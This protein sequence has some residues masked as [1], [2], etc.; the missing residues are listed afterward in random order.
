MGRPLLRPMS[1]QIASRHRAH[2]FLSPVIRRLLPNAGD[3][4]SFRLYEGEGITRTGEG[5]MFMTAAEGKVVGLSPEFIAVRTGSTRFDV[6]AA[7]CMDTPVAVGNTVKLRYYTMR[8]FDGLRADGLRDGSAATRNTTG[9]LADDIRVQLPLRWEGKPI[10]H[11]P[12]HVVS[13]YPLAR[14]PA[15]VTLAQALE[16]QMVGALRNIPA[17]LVDAGAS[18]IG[19]SEI[20]IQ[21]AF[22]KPMA[23]TGIAR[24][25]MSVR[26]R[27]FRGNVIFAYDEVNK[28]YGL[29][30]ESEH[31][32]Q[33]SACWEDLRP[34][35]LARKLMDHVDDGRWRL[36]RVELLDVGL[37]EPVPVAAPGASY[38]ER[39]REARRMNTWRLTLL[40]ML[41]TVIAVVFMATQGAGTMDLL[42]WVASR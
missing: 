36:V 19:V 20:P 22:G 9:V 33:A 13:S 1:T 10:E 12:A 29:M 28:R 34:E 37:P 27:K 16:A 18:R 8:R 31:A 41:V 4:F 7:E 38:R 26:T 6:V 39:E 30:L 21:N 5:M 25:S 2:E 15:L 11:E 23:G 32:A 14:T 42:Q 35:D 40:T 24:I 17:M 3:D